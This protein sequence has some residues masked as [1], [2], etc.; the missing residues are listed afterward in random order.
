MLI[1]R[2][3]ELQNNLYKGLHEDEGKY[4]AAAAELKKWT[5]SL[6]EEMKAMEECFVVF[7]D[8][9]IRFVGEIKWGSGLALEE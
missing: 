1:E 4:K 6:S 8:C 9:L 5:S 7:N 3:R 2:V